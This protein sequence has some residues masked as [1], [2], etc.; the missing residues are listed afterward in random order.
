MKKT[1]FK[2]NPRCLLFRGKVLIY[3][4][5]DV[6]GKNHLQQA[7]TFDPDLKECMVL[8]K[9]TRTAT[10]MK[11]EA[12]ESFKA[13]NYEEAI[14]QFNKCLELDQLNASYN[15]TLL[16]NIAIAQ[17][18]LG[19]KENAIRTLHKAVKYN[20][21]YAKAY[22]KLGELQCDIG[23]FNDAVRSFSTASEYDQVGFGV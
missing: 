22:V 16:L 21:K 8:V 20:P 19:D 12:A 2:N 1:Q 5:A 18:K 6:I 7:M 13:G 3:T 14:E 9:L 4:G 10:K 11:E 15:S 23:E 17:T